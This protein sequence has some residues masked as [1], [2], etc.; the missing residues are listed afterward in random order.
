MM[1][2]ISCEA[3]S[4]GWDWRVPLDR[5]P[6]DRLQQ[7]GAP[8]RSPRNRPLDRSI[9]AG[10]TTPLQAPLLNFL[11]GFKGQLIEPDIYKVH[12]L[13]SKPNL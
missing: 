12:V 11:H 13:R 2:P 7:E 3:D 1:L 6:P 4:R 8:P 10:A 5:C 9:S